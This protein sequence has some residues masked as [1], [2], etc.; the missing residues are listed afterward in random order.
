[1][2][3]GPG[4]ELSGASEWETDPPVRVLILDEQLIVRAGLRVTLDAC[5]NCEVVGEAVDGRSA[6]QM[7][8]A[9]VPDVVLMDARMSGGDA[10]AL[11]SQLVGPD[12]RPPRVLVVTNVE[13]PECVFDSLRAGASGF[14][15]KSSSADR[16]VEAVHTVRAGGMPLDPQVTRGMVDTFLQLSA[17]PLDE[18]FAPGSLSTREGQI[19]S[20]LAR[21]LNTAEV[22]DKLSLS[23][24][25]VKTHVS[26]ILAKWGLRDRVQLVARAYESGFVQRFR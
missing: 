11:I 12:Q 18:G 6:M 7:S 8:R 9:L 22:A 21:G 14:I 13:V 17:T 16:I 25:T 5:P 15:L 2:V 10:I 26:H 4:T 1:V 24:P 20:L 3:E 19:V 23:N